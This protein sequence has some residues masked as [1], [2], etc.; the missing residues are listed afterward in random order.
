MLAYN[1]FTRGNRLVLSRLDAFAHELFTFLTTGA[2]L[3]TRRQR[4]RAAPKPA[5]PVRAAV[6]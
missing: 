3:V 1:F 2:Q 6:A 5:A 4:P